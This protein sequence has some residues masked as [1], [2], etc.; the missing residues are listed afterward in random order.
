MVRK[1][2]IALIFLF[3]VS[4]LL[5]AQ[6]SDSVKAKNLELNQLKKEVSALESELRSKSQKEKESVQ[7]LQNISHQNLLLNKLINNLLGEEK[8]KQKQIDRIESQMDS[9]ESRISILKDKYSRYIVWLYKNMGSPYLKYLVDASSVNQAIVRYK[10]LQYITGENK[11]TLTNLKES[12][13]ELNGLKNNL[14]KEIRDKEALIVQKQGEQET[15]QQKESERKELITKLKKDQDAITDEIAEKRKAEIE[16]KNIIAKL[17]E[18]ERE[19]KSRL[20]ERKAANP[21]LTYDYDYDKLAN[22]SGL[23]GSLLWPIRDGKVVR[24]FGE[25]KNERLN[26]VTLNYGIDISVKGSDDVYAVAEGIVSAIDWI[27][28]YG[29]VLIITHKNEFRTVYGHISNINVS[30]GDK[31]EGGTLLGKVNDSLEGNILHF[32]IWNERN[33]QNPEVWLVKK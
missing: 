10:Y 33:F 18:R 31:V 20:L 26:T 25:N 17:I 30:E 15:L 32:E 1:I 4:H 9:V 7:V 8:L 14:S 5:L 29:S 27:P 28:G 24:K 23:K 22:F 6:N 21:S 16:I 19:R 12:K 13:K 2:N 11:R 3:T